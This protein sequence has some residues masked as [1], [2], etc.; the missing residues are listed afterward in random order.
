MS[1]LRKQ[2]DIQAK[3]SL[4]EDQSQMIRIIVDIDIDI[5]KDCLEPVIKNKALLKA[6]VRLIEGK[7]TTIEIS[8]DDKRALEK[9]NTTITRYLSI[10]D[11]AKRIK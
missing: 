11:K 5:L 3:D 2:I 7:K 8:S 6:D 4:K 9:T 10:L 1:L